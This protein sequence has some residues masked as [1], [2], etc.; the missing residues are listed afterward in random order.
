MSKR[1]KATKKHFELEVFLNEK[2]TENPTF[3]VSVGTKYFDKPIRT[4]SR[5]FIHEVIN[6]V[7]L[8][9][10]KAETLRAVVIEAK[11][12]YKIVGNGTTLG[13]LRRVRQA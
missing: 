12:L 4:L 8:D 3:K 6:A 7:G 2:G 13:L 10:T 5:K 9:V 1:R 11:E